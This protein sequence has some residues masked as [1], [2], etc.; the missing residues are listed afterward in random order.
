[1]IR[2]VILTAAAVLTLSAG[3]VAAHAEEASLTVSAQGLDL[4]TPAG[5]K[6]FYRRV[7]QA[8]ADLCGSGAAAMTADTYAY[9]RCQR[10]AVSAVVAKV[11][12]PLVSALNGKVPAAKAPVEMAAR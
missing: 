10:A 2:T 4:N 5:A 11:N 1:M 8:A 9:S 6:T 7:S 12:M 3:A